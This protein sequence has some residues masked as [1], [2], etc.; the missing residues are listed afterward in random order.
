[1]RT[2]LEQQTIN[3]KSIYK[4]LDLS[5]SI[6]KTVAITLG[7]VCHHIHPAIVNKIIQSNIVFKREFQDVCHDADIN[8]FFYE[9]SDCIFPGV[10]RN[11][12]KEKQ[13]KWKNNINPTDYTILND[14][15]FPRHIWAFLSMNK[16]YAGH[17]WAES[18]LSKFELAHIFGHKQD[19]KT[20][21]KK[22]FNQFDEKKKPYAYFTS[23]SNVILLPNGLMKP[24]DKFAI[25]SYM[26][27]IF[28][29]KMILITNLFQNGMMK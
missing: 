19:E 4:F 21:E 5:E 15:T 7:K 11:I 25:S 20:L 17:M 16:P 12:N 28:M 9:G 3:R 2:T 26:E 18:G 10:R 24:T 13:G 6:E 29:L 22:V 1:M 14:N 23:A 8:T 27:I